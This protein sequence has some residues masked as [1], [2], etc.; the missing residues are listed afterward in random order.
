MA[1]SL[2]NNDFHN[3]GVPA[4]NGLPED[5]GRATGTR[6][7][8]TDEFNCLSPY[9]DAKEGDCAEL[10][11]MVIDGHDLERQF[12][13]PSLRNVAARGPFMHAGQFETLEGVLNHYNTAPEAPMGHSE[14]E[15]LGLNEKQI[16]QIIAF[17]KT[18]D[19]PVD[20]EPEWLRMP[21]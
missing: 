21:N 3:T 6:Q 13:P 16:A 2:P 15:P 1:H 17:L 5:D 10:T 14:L 7:V 19:S 9:S 20:A 4:A 8:L 12:K 11:Y 18:L